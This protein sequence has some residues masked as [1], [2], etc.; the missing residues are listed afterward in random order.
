MSIR[1]NKITGGRFGNKILQYNSL[2]QIANNN[3]IIASCCNWEGNIFFKII[4][5]HIETKNK[6]KG[7]FCK[8]ILDDEKLDFQNFD[9]CIDDPAGAIHNFF[10]KITNK[11][12]RCFLD[13]YCTWCISYN[14]IKLQD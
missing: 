8:S 3:N 5:S 14:Q 7:L 10:Y 2:L 6:M 11:D 13:H 4:V 12:P 9:Y 1:I